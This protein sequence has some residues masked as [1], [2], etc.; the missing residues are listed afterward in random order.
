MK[1]K[2]FSLL[3]LV[4]LTFGM[5]GQ[6]GA[7][8][9]GNVPEYTMPVGQWL[10]IDLDYL[11]GV[12]HGAVRIYHANGNFDEPVPAGASEF[13]LCNLGMEDT[14]IVVIEELDENGDVVDYFV[15]RLVMVEPID[16]NEINQNQTL[17]M[18][19][20]EN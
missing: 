17:N 20:H 6:L 12:G 7:S 16:T 15:F 8:S 3:I 18:L 10:R 4:S 13:W 11:F 9:T 1:V 2:I 14:G 5:S 19:L